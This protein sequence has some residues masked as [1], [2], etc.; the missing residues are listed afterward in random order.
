MNAPGSTLS[1]LH[2]MHQCFI[3][4][5]QARAFEEE[6]GRYQLRLQAQLYHCSRLIQELDR[7]E[8][9][10]AMITIDGPENTSE[11]KERSI[12]ET[13]LLEMPSAKRSAKL[14]RFKPSS[15]QLP[16]SYKTPTLTP[17]SIS[18]QC[19]FG[20]RGF[21]KNGRCKQRRQLRQ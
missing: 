3:H 19:K 17:R 6:F 16:S 2:L 18:R 14:P 11:E 4:T 9:S 15:P 10:L 20:L 13:L 5:Q 1:I 12:V 7:T 8:N 21:L